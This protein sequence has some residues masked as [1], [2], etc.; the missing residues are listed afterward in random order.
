[1]NYEIY[2]K[3]VLNIYDTK[4]ADKTGFW[5]EGYNFNEIITNTFV[6]NYVRMFFIMAHVLF[7]YMFRPTWAIFR[8]LV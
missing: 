4:I 3:N 2:N 8:Y 7:Y 6:R 5:S 1:M